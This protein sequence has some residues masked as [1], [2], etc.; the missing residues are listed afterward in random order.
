VV[1]GFLLMFCTTGM[2]QICLV[3]H[4]EKLREVVADVWVQGMKSLITT[5]LICSFKALYLSFLL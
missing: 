5:F 4:V 3:R 2:A 1:A